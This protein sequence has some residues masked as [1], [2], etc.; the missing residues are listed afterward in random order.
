M[1]GR[2]SSTGAFAC[3]PDLNTY[4]C[5]DNDGAIVPCTIFTP[6]VISTYYAESRHNGGWGSF[7]RGEGWCAET[8]IEWVECQ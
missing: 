8:G 7:L 1:A 4:H 6:K 5:E 2:P 3:A